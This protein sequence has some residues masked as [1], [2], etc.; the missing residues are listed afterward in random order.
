MAT[1]ISELVKMIVLILYSYKYLNIGISFY[2]IR[3]ILLSSIMFVAI[4]LMKKTILF[5]PIFINTLGLILIGGIIYF[6]ILFFIRDK[7]I[8]KIIK[9]I[10]KK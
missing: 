5:A 8:Q 10:V 6:L 9:T 3:Y 1:I 7:Y 2:C 4:L